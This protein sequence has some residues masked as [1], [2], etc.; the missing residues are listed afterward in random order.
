[1]GAD[2]PAA[3]FVRCCAGAAASDLSGSSFMSGCLPRAVLAGTGG[4]GVN[5]L[6]FP[7]A[8]PA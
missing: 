4:S 3:A 2:W 1:L 7:C 8:S 5:R 6:V